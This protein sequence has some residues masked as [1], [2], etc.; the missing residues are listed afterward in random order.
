MVIPSIE[1]IFELIKRGATIEAQEEIVRLR[2]TAVSLQ[3]E[4]LE[5]KKE[6]FSLKQ[7]IEKYE[8]YTGERCPKCNKPTWKIID[9]KPDPIFGPLGSTRRTYKCSECEHTEEV[10]HES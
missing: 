10:L 3:E 8:N 9:S 6:N 2:E 4:N 5:L 7:Q 1:K